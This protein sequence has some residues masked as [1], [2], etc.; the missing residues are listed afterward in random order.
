MGADATDSNAPD[1]N[2]PDSNA[3]DSNAPDSNAPD[4]N[5]PDRESPDYAILIPA[6]YGSERLQGKVLLAESG[7]YLI[8]HVY[9]QAMRA[10]D[11]R[12][13][14]V[15]TDDDR[16]EDAVI[17]FGGRVRM[18]GAQHASG[19]DRCAE[20]ARS[21]DEAVV[22]NVQGD[23]PLF[24]PGDLE[25]LARAVAHEGADIATLGWPFG[26]EA[27]L[28]DPHAVKAIVGEDGW[29]L[30]FCRSAERA[31]RLHIECKATILHHVGIYAFRRDR[32]LEFADMD[33]TPRETAEHLEQLR[34]VENG[35]RV[36][37]LPATVPAFGVDTRA[38]YEAF[39]A[40]L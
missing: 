24:E 27:L 14:L 1:S 21:L 15:L 8:Q 35:W 33:A 5:A 30:D 13:V 20:A 17:S 26:N 9:E 32:L 2:A 19:T 29:A 12:T 28:E 10:R 7:K 37:V 4:S 16:V 34:A 6:R 23:E 40:R 22:V 36:K 11:V 18:T 39:L 31:R 25:A 38:D 3:P